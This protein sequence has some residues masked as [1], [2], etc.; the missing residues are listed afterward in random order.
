MGA[1][2]SLITGINVFEAFSFQGKVAGDAKD[3]ERPQAS[4]A[5]TASPRREQPGTERRPQRR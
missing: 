1:E 3:R 5:N 4:L 2:P